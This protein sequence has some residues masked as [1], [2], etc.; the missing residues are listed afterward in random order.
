MLVRM[1]NSEVFPVCYSDK[2]FV[3]FSLDYI[4]FKDR[5]GRFLYHNCQ[6]SRSTGNILLKIMT[7][8]AR[9][10]NSLDPDQ[11]S[12]FVGPDPFSGFQDIKS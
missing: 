1:A 7:I 2:H 11:D 6:R 12:H 8:T 5:K 3:N 10:S 9:V 4:L